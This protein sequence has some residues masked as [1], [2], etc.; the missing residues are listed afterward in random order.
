MAFDR[1]FTPCGGLCSPARSS[2]L[3]GTYPHRHEVLTNVV[4]HPV[5]QSLDKG[6]DVLVSGLKAAGYRVGVRGQVACQP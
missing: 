4:L 3:T 5:R 1:A 6:R 2:L